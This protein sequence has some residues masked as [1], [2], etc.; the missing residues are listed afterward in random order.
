VEHPPA[1][2]DTVEATARE[3]ETNSDAPVHPPVLQSLQGAPLEADEPVVA[4]VVAKHAAEG[5]HVSCCTPPED[6]PAEVAEVVSELVEVLELIAGAG[7]RLM[8][9]PK[10]EEEEEA[11]AEEKE[12]EEEEEEE[13]EI[14]PPPCR[15]VEG[16][17]RNSESHVGV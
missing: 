2:R 12:E 7:K 13:E 14:S 6:I 10:E 5:A 8:Q 15:M 16:E 17:E 4:H 3:F 1:T 11:E 9:K